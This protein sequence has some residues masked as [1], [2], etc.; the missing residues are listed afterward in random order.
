VRK[1]TAEVRNEG[2]TTLFRAEKSLKEY[3]DKIPAPIAS[4]IQGHVDALKKALEGQDG[5]QIKAKTSAL[6][7]SMQKIGEELSKA[8]A[9]QPQQQAS[10]PSG[11]DTVEEAEVEVMEETK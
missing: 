8:G 3:K 1:E 7:E 4:E 5:E 2:D 11:Q 9:E 10:A 6:N